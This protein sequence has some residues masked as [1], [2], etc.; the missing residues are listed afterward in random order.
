MTAQ[1]YVLEDFHVSDSTGYSYQQP[2]LSV[3]P[4]G[5]AVYT[6]ET[7]GGNGILMKM[8]MDDLQ[9]L[10][11]VKRV[12]APFYH[13]HTWVCHN[14]EGGFM[15][16]YAASAN[17]WQLFAQLYD[18]DGNEIGDT[19]TV[20]RNYTEFI[21]WFGASVSLNDQDQFVVMFPGHDS[22]MVE[23]ISAEGNFEG[24]MLSL[25]PEMNSG[26]GLKGLAIPSG[27]FIL[28]WIE[29]STRQ[30]MVQLFNDEGSSSG[31]PVEVLM[32]EEGHSIDGQLISCNPSGD[33]VLAWVETT[34]GQ[35]E[36]FTKLY[37]AG[38][39]PLGDPVKIV[40]E[41]GS[42]KGPM[43]L[44]MDEDGKFVVAWSDGRRGDT[45]FIF[46]QQMDQAGEPVGP[47]VQAT[48]I[49]DMSVNDQLLATQYGSGVR[50]LHDTIYL[51]WENN[52]PVRSYTQDIYAS[53]QLW[54]TYEGTVVSPA[55]PGTAIKLFPNPSRGLI[56]LRFDP[57]VNGEATL[58]IYN[59]LG[60]MIDQYTLK[61]NGEILIDLTD[62]SAGWYYLRYRIGN[63]T[64]GEP[65]I[66]L[67]H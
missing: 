34:D 6:W 15:I 43:S 56:T 55:V 14:A 5:N 41:P 67:D 26:F 52:D 54:E 20:S 64:A 3:G 51:V 22:V 33:F 61:H 49:N 36:I 65:F 9:N 31:G 28:S 23:R 2:A 47:N 25:V 17:G 44:D 7:A 60:A 66:L 24:E 42:Y 62:R 58:E 59:S 11:D 19:I 18:T 29:L 57:S 16:L 38:G 46:L 1:E 13:D 48:H 21:D 53:I 10:S 4:N 8:L 35:K 12:T 32:P 27:G 45:T 39:E 40:D 30:L 37:H 50:I 63:R